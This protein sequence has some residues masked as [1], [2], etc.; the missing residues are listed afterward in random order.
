MKTKIK[1][2]IYVFITISSILILLLIGILFYSQWQNKLSGKVIYRRIS[3]TE[4]FQPIEY[5]YFLVDFDQNFTQFL[6]RY[7]GTPSISRDGKYLAINDSFYSSI[8]IIDI[9]NIKSSQYVD[10]T[11]TPQ[12]TTIKSIKLPDECVQKLTL[13]DGLQSISWNY[14]NEKLAVV[15]GSKDQINKDNMICIFDIKND[16][17]FCWKE[18]K[19]LFADYSPKNN[20]ILL[21]ID[22]DKIYKIKDDDVENKQFLT[23]GVS[24]TWSP[25]GKKF[26]V[27]YES[28]IYLYDI[29]KE[30]IKLIYEKEVNEYGEEYKNYNF[31]IFNGIYKIPHFS[32]SPNGRSIT[33]HAA[34]GFNVYVY[35]IYT[36][37][38]YTKEVRC[39]SCFNPNFTKNLDPT[40]GK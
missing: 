9:S 4:K 22:G 33:F 1:D 11:N 5:Q 30:T 39:L 21:S 29:N 34:R 32:W 28:K 23:D 40:W 17:H 3:K 20:E 12:T 27:G 19:V 24:A 35:N 8:E 18:E 13:Y 26:V 16:S 36:M 6:G 10:L 7:N 15:C 38:I 2:N 31:H 25:D 14:T 37:N